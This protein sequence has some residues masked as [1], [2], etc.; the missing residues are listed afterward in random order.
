MD[1]LQ[2]LRRRI[3]VAAVSIGID[4]KLPSKFY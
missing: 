3:Y 4:L 1:H 2:T